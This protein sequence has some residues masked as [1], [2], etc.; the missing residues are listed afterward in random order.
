MVVDATE[1]PIANSPLVGGALRRQDVVGTPLAE[2]VFGLV[3]A[4]FLQD[5]RIFR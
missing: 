3:D 5:S 1:R 2:Q 4:I